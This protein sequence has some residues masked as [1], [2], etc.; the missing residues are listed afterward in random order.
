MS[1]LLPPQIG[2]GQY[3]AIR[4]NQHIKSKFQ[5]HVHTIFRPP[6]NHRRG[7]HIEYRPY[8]R[9]HRERR[10]K[11]SRDGLRNRFQLEDRGEVKDIWDVHVVCGVGKIEGAYCVTRDSVV[12][13]VRRG[14]SD[15]GIE[16][17]G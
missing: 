14:V 8:R 7:D 16:A 10:Y 5:T 4:I 17:G 9:Q 11:D 1:P 12:V 3:V 15:A 2:H 13:D 6:N